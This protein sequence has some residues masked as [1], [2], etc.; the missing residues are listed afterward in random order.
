M[1]CV[2]ANRSCEGSLD[3][4]ALLPPP[5]KPR[6]L[7]RLAPRP[8]GSGAHREADTRILVTPGLEAALFRHQKQWDYF[9]S[10]VLNAEQGDTVMGE[11]TLQ[12]A[13][14]ET[15]VREM[16][17]GVGAMGKALHYVFNDK[18][19]SAEY[20]QALEHYGRAAKAVF[21]ASTTA[22]ANNLPSVILTSFLFTT[23][24]MMAGNVDSAANHH[25]Y[26]VAMM[27]QHIDLR[28]EREG[29]PLERLR[30]SQLETA[31]FERLMRHDT[32]PWALGFGPECLRTIA[33]ARRFPHCR[34]RNTMRDIPAVFS[35][36]SQAASWWHFTQH[37]VLHCLHE[38][39]I[40]TEIKTKTRSR[41]R[42]KTP[43]EE[44]LWAECV[45]ILRTWRASFAPLLQAA[46]RHRDR[47]HR[48]WFKAMTLETLYIETLSAVYARHRPDGGSGGADLPLPDVSPLH[49]EMIRHAARLA[50]ARPFNGVETMVAENDV[51]RP[52][53][54]VQFKTR[55]PAVAR[56]LTAVLGRLRGGVGVAETLLYMHACREGK[57]PL[58]ALER[59]WGWSFTT[60]GMTAGAELLDYLD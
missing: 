30:F 45:A 10:F 19:L 55:D 54:Y 7:A 21:S 27:E 34:H 18:L 14:A 6:G 57:R 23:F 43:A 25:H 15:A 53:A 33:P 37:A 48:H 16:C 4:D 59:G 28:V 13:Y 39:K 29:V 58:K 49:L 47:D 31:M 51:V 20:N 40:K 26:A 5:R 35:D 38:I 8:A 22:A 56:E 32:H 44:K 36:V 41:T 12:C 3:S 2:K 50:E 46:R 42:T 9:Q 24:E 11:V 17:C 52:L 1:R 60:V